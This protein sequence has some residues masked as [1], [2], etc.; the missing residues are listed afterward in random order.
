MENM[1]FK[2]LEDSALYV[3]IFNQ[4][5]TDVACRCL[6]NISVLLPSD[7]IG[8]LDHKNVNKCIFGKK[9]FNFV[10]FCC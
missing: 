1:S 6:L 5:I 4:Y 3:K 2:C 9:Y 7:E 8:S 10:Y